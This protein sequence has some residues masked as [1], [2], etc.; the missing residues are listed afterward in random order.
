ML[1][2]PTICLIIAPLLY[3]YIFEEI[4]F[5]LKFMNFSW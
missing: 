4:N 2:V 3:L 5:V 1:Y